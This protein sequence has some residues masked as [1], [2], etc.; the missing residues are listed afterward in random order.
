[1]SDSFI[2]EIR[3]L[4]YTF[5]PFE[6]AHCN[7]QILPISQNQVLFAV[8]GSTFGGN[9]RTTMGVPDLMGRAPI[10]A[11][12]G[13]GLTQRILGE[14][15]GS[16]GVSLNYQTIPSH[17][18]AISGY[19]GAGTAST[20]DDTLMPSADDSADMVM[21]SEPDANMDSMA[22]ETLSEAGNSYPHENRQPFLV[23]PYCLS[24]SGIFPSRN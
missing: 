3:I 20:P 5:A 8:I 9:W 7:G 22:Y 13:P 23:I 14:F 2:G 24:L 12:A 18:H 6:W 19:L 16:S 17:T 10:G 21:Y 4:P 15:G 11:G 1:M